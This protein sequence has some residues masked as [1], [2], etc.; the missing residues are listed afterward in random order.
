[1]PDRQPQDETYDVVVVGSGLGGLAAAAFLAKAGKKVLVV[2]RLDGPGGYAHAFTRDDYVFD[3]AVHAVGQCG[4]GLMLDTWLRALGVRDRVDMIPLDPFYTICLPDF[5]MTVPFGVEE[6]IQA[7]LEHFPEEEEGLRGFMALC[8]R[9]RDEWD[10]AKPATTLE[11]LQ[12]AAADFPTVLQYRSSSVSQA[13]DEHI[14]DPR[15]KTVVSALWGYQGV[16]PSILGFVSFAGMLVSLLEGGQSYCRGSF[17]NLVNAWVSALEENGGQVIVNAEVTGIGVSD[18]RVTGV[19]LDD[20]SEVRASIVVSNADARR[21]FEMLGADD[22]PASYV[23]RL[24]RMTTSTSAFLVYAAT[25]LDVSR[26]DYAHEIFVYKSWD[27]D[28]VWRD[29]LDGKLSAMAV[30]APTEADPSLAPEGEHIVT[31]VGFVPYDLG[32][33]WSDV[34]ERYTETV[35]DEL[36]RLYPGIRDQLTFVESATPYALEKYSLNSSGAIYGWENNVRQAHARRLGNQTPV[37]GL[38]LASAWAQPGSG[39]IAVMQSGFQTAQ[40]IMG[41]ADKNEFLSSLGFQPVS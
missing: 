40:I 39:T 41:H 33:D 25:T 9:I 27:L 36:E 2:E 10:M 1:M 23:R 3:P 20:G 17:Q 11:E 18:G 21:T 12:E 13:M 32:T 29:T 30:T 35:L 28:E 22:L 5:E 4:E 14:S 16:P 15:L 37:E 38:Y 31:T 7:H 6:F 34:R 24:E 8:T 26:F 19:T